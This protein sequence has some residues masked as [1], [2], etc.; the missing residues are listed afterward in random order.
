MMSIL[1]II[2]FGATS[3]VTPNI[4]SISDYHF[5]TIPTN[6]VIVQGWGVNESVDVTTQFPKYS[7]Y[8]SFAIKGKNGALKHCVKGLAF[9]DYTARIENLFWLSEAFAE[10]YCLTMNQNPLSGLGVFG[11]SFKNRSAFNNP[12]EIQCPY[13]LKKVPESEDFVKTVIEINDEYIEGPVFNDEFLIPAFGGEYENAAEGWFEKLP[14]IVQNAPL[15][16]E[17]CTT[18]M[19]GFLDEFKE[20]VSPRVGGDYAHAEYIYESTK[21][22]VTV[23][24]I[25]YDYDT[26][27]PKI[28]HNVWEKEDDTYNSIGS[29][30]TLSYDFSKE[31]MRFAYA[32]GYNGSIKQY[33]SVSDGGVSTY[34]DSVVTETPTKYVMYFDTQSFE[35]DGVN[36]GGVNRLVSSDKCFVIHGFYCKYRYSQKVQSNIHDDADPIE[37]S[38]ETVVWMLDRNLGAPTL[39]RNI[40][41]A[42]YSGKLSDDGYYMKIQIDVLDKMKKAFAFAFPVGEG[43]FESLGSCAAPPDPGLSSAADMSEGVRKY[44]GDM[45]TY[46]EKEV[47][48][49]VSYYGV[50][51][52][53][54]FFRFRTKPNGGE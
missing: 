36:A 15:R 23:P 26:K 31:Q 46:S 29:A 51:A 8:D 53:G 3:L 21:A 41:D 12:I 16:Y 44:G 5:I 13:F 11:L 42:D 9:T 22:A 35:R 20:G 2:L 24:Y 33:T 39:G 52:G 49:E 28:K 17:D 37:Y 50:W 7:N 47:F 27:Q 14:Q 43:I 18:R 32:D 6:D 4:S 1:S 25:D 30:I 48:Q 54:K 34:H 10:R 19:F 45:S 40:S 38:C